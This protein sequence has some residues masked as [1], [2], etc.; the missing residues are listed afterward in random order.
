MTSESGTT[1]IVVRIGYL[2]VE[3]AEVITAEVAAGIYL[4]V[5][6]AP[7]SSST[8][9]STDTS[10][11]HDFLDFAAEVQMP[12]HRQRHLHV[13]AV[14]PDEVLVGQVAVDDDT[15]FVAGLV[16]EREIH[17]GGLLIAIPVGYRD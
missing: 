11:P 13:T 8:E 17:I 15:L 7:S 1:T 16:F 12:E 3:I 10:M 2:C 5:Q 14:V 9:T 4:D 6:L